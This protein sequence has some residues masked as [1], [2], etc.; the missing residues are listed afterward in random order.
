MTE[1]IWYFA[2]GTNMSRATLA[3]RG[4]RPSSSEAA[5]L[6]GYRLRFSHRGLVFVEP[7][8]ANIEADPS[9]SM[10]GV[11]HRLESGQ[12]ARLDR[13]EGAEY[14]HVVVD[15]V[16]ERSGVVRARAYLDPNLAP[17]L[18]PS[19]RYLRACCAGAREHGLPEDY[20]RALEEQPCLHVP[21]VSHVSNLLVG[22]A[23]R[24]RYAGLRPERLRMARRAKG[25]AP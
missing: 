4:L 8:F 11:L 24:L 1:S 14:V 7:A 3:R 22:A 25:G 15:V 12:L 10:H 17:G 6:D 16:G 2:Y 23:E 19:R 13:F 20:V 9:A 18:Q 21:V 5:R